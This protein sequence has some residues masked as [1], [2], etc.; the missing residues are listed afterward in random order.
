MPSSS[1]CYYNPT[2]SILRSSCALS[3]SYKIYKRSTAFVCPFVIDTFCP[4]LT[5]AKS[6]FL[7]LCHLCY[8]SL[9]HR[10][11]ILMDQQQVLIQV[12]MF[13]PTYICWIMICYY[14]ISLSLSFYLYPYVDFGCMTVLFPR[15]STYQL[16]IEEIIQY[17]CGTR[18]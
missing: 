9:K 16:E 14:Q 15:N 13:G 4:L 7:H 5:T 11:L 12:G 8:R 17:L 18:C 2:T 3:L 10:H 1:R 6:F